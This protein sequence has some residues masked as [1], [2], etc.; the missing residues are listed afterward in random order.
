MV[1]PG[2][3]AFAQSIHK[4]RLDFGLSLQ[5]IHY[6]GYI[7]QSP[8]SKRVSPGVSGAS[9]FLIYIFIIAG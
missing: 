1:S 7:L 4:N 2:G 3:T 9:S 6:K 8:L 5:T